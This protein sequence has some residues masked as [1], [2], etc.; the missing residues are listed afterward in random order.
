MA[1]LMAAR[2]VVAKDVRSAVSMVHG[3]VVSRA[4][5]WD[6]NAVEK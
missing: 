1:K 6:Q 2:W 5:Y 3:L 4:G